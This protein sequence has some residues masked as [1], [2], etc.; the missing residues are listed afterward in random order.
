MNNSFCSTKFIFVTFESLDEEFKKRKERIGKDS[1]VSFIE[2]KVDVIHNRYTISFDCF[3]IL[4][5]FVSSKR[6]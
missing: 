2:F 4:A 6:F 5:T 3:Y 1:Y